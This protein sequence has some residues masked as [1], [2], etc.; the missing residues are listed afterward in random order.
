MRRLKPAFLTDRLGPVRIFFSRSP[1]VAGLLVLLIF[2]HPLIWAEEVTEHDV[3]PI[4]LRRCSLCHAAGD[5]L[6]GN[7]DLRSKSTI[8]NGGESGPAI[9]PGEASN[10]LLVAHITKGKMPPKESLG[11]AGIEA[12]TRDELEVIRDWI[13]AGAPETPRMEEEVTEAKKSDVEHWAFQPLRSPPGSNHSI[14]RFLRDKLEKNGLSFSPEASPLALFRRASF[15]LT[16]LPPTAHEVRRFA[17]AAKDNPAGA[18]EEAVDRFLESPRYGERWGRVWLDLAGYADS[19]G[20]RHAD[21]IRDN[22]W[23]YRDYVIRS[24]NEDKP[25]DLFLLEQLAGD[26]LADY[27]QATELTQG[28]YDNLVAT[29]FLRMA[30]DGTTANPVNR[31]ED[32]LE[33][34]SDQIRVLTEGVMGLTM[35]CARCHDH[36]YDPLSQ[37]DYYSLLAVFKGAYDEYDWLI[38]QAFRNQSKRMGYRLLDLGLPEEE[39]AWKAAVAAL[40]RQIEQK[41]RN[42]AEAGHDSKQRKKLEQEIKSLEEK[43]P[44]RPMI[45]ALWDRGRPS[46]TYVLN[47][48]NHLEPV[49]LVGPGVPMILSGLPADYSIESPPSLGTGRRLA[50]A[51]WLTQAE[52]PLTARVLVNRIWQQHFGRGIVES[53]DNFGKLGSDPSHPE[54]LDFLASE[55]VENGWSIKELHRRIVLSQ[56]WKQRSRVT[57]KHEKL[58]PEN[59]LLARYP[60]RR[61]TAE[62]VRD[63]IIL[64]GGR[65]DETPFGKPDPVAVRKDGLVTSAEFSNPETKLRRSIYLRHRRKEMPTILETFDQPAMNPNCAKRI[66]SSVV[67]QPLYLLNNSMIYQLAGDFAKNMAASASKDLEGKVSEA[68][69]A[70]RNEFPEPGDLRSAVAALTEL[71]DEWQKTIA[72]DS[73]KESPEERAFADFCHTLLNSAGFLYID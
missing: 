26:E 56:A 59:L 40:E 67:T 50:F 5:E 51:K 54:L 33:V 11:E 64:L 47:R 23:R 25:Y 36:K 35:E 53:V 14:D 39:T 28:L 7:L 24:L 13:D 16:G 21:M 30:P 49:S 10:S 3:L 66:D 68:W 34:I 9:V 63:S 32:R 1:R 20:K 18:F 65:L 61:L 31:V 71:T 52:H 8:L 37:R 62:E 73:A 43:K 48:G 44:K 38:P 72:E 19:E 17:A 45:R 15:M 22:A 57:K 4:L 12:V 70:A 6:G 60:M 41:K 55:F 58:D 42:L 27:E 2:V 29:G 46:N 69:I